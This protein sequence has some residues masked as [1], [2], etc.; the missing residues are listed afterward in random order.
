M[1][2]DKSPL[3]DGSLGP[4]GIYDQGLTVAEVCGVSK[5]PHAAR[6]LHSLADEYQPKTTIE[7]GTNVG[8]SSAYLAA[9]G[10]HVTTFDVSPYR[11]RLARSLHK[12][13]RLQVRYEEGLFSDALEKA[14]VRLPPVE[15]AFIDGH[16]QYQ[17][18]LDYFQ[19]IAEN[20]RPGCIFI[21]DDIR[22][23]AGMRR[24]W[25]DLRRS[26]RFKQVADLGGM[27]V[28]ILAQSNS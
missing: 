19:M 20:A 10:A 23:S 21:F 22:W 27:G 9:G 7:L 6:L 17:P 2:R 11:Q 18:T 4:G 3:V 26:P 8:I 25:A 15:M 28:A 5:P 16:H 12:S 13:L 14:L 1:L 24:A